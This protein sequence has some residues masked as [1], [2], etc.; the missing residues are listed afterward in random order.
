MLTKNTRLYMADWMPMSRTRPARSAKRAAS[1]SGRPNS[2]TSSAP[3]TPKR[4]VI[5]AFMVASSWYASRVIAA[6][7]LPTR[8]AGKM[9]T[10][11]MTSDSRVTCQE[12]VSIT[13]A[14]RT[15]WMTLLTT[16]DRVEVNA[17]WA[18]CTS[19][20]SRLTRAPVWVRVKNCSGMSCT[21]PYTWVRSDRMMPSPMRAEYHRWTS[22]SSAS[23]TA[24]APMS[25]ATRTTAVPAPGP[26]ALILLMTSPARYGVATPMAAP[27]TTVT[28]KTLMSPR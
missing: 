15:S 2:L 10:G 7:R 8:R 25:S 4:S 22:D 13:T 1:V 18:P 20:L 14:V 21:W 3:A 19:L 11:S 9:K 28:R 5:V 17:R 27:R 16:P 23:T 12:R 24:R 6:R 26:P